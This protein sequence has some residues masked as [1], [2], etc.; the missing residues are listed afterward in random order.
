MRSE[1]KRASTSYFLEAIKALIIAVIITL[2][3]ILVEAVVI[4]FCNIPTNIIP[5]L[6]QIIKG[7]SILVGILIAMKLP[8][9]GWVRGIIIGVLYIA[10]SFVV[11]S[12]MQH[13]FNIGINILNDVAIGAVTG[14]ISGIIA[15][16]VRGGR[17]LAKSI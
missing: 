13:K 5:I 15:A 8:H 1:T 16:N 9:N 3:L 17:A 11:F 2:V 6:N 7:I 10:I 4:K 12:L 14:M